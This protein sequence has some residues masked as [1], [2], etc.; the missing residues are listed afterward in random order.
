MENQKRNHYNEEIEPQIEK[1]LYAD[2]Y[3]FMHFYMQNIFIFLLTLEDM[4]TL[5]KQEYV[6]GKNAR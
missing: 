2:S 6:F 5:Q 1:D 3:F 4:T